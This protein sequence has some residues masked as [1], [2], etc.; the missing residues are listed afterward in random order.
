MLRLILI[1]AVI[2]LVGGG[3]AAVIGPFAG[4]DDTGSTAPVRAA[5][6]AEGQPASPVDDPDDGEEVAA[7]LEDTEEEGAAVVI[8]A[9]Q[10]PAS[11]Q[12]PDDFEGGTITTPDG[13]EIN[14][15]VDENGDFR[16]EGLPNFGPGGPGGQRG[17]GGRGNFGPAG[18]GGQPSFER[19]TII[20]PDGQEVNIFRVEVEETEI[21]NLTPIGPGGGGGGGG[22]Q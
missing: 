1:A 9:D 6:A 11:L 10:V 20:T 2:G 22:G 5:A 17:F 21:Q 19:E 13:R 16:I 8:P 4:S 3:A 7:E 14:I 12:I 15:T 18:P